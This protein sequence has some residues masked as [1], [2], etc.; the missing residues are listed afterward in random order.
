MRPVVQA[1]RSQG[2]QSVNYLDDFLL[3]GDSFQDCQ[4]TVR[5]TVIFLQFLGFKISQEKCNL[6]PKTQQRF[7]WFIIDSQTMSINL[8]EEKREKI[9]KLTLKFK[10]KESCQIREFAQFI[11]ILVSSCPA[12]KYGFL[13]TKSLE[14]QTF[15]ALRRSNE[16]YE[17]KMFCG[18]E[19][20]EDLVWWMDN[21]K[22]TFNPIRDDFYDLEIF[23][24]A[25]LSGWGA[26]ADGT[27]THGWWNSKE[28]EEHIN[29]LELKAVVYGLNYINY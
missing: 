28:K 26:T 21:I 24:D 2:F 4:L 1:F 19:L 5:S 29:F 9:L 27:Q 22:I 7:L 25:S 23:S 18:S 13:Y 15:L 17:A 3:I 11:G 14:R 12:V 20:H 6:I 8:T 16:N 10:S